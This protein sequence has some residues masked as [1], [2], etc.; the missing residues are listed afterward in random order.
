MS[1]AAVAGA[2]IGL[3]GG[4]L[5]SKASKDNAQTAQNM[6]AEDWARYQQYNQQAL[7]ANRPTQVNA[8]GDKLSW[9]QDDKGNWIQTDKFSPERQAL[10][11]SQ[12]NIAGNRMGAAQGI[13][14]SRYSRGIDYNALGMGNL[15]QA[16][17]GAPSTSKS[18]YPTEG[19]T[20]YNSAPL[21]PG[22]SGGGMGPK[23]PMPPGMMG[24]SG[25]GN[26]MGG[27]PWGA[28][29]AFAQQNPNAG[30]DMFMA[31]QPGI[32]QAMGGQGPDPMMLDQLKAQQ[33]AMGDRMSQA[34]SGTMG[35][36]NM[37]PPAMMDR[38]PQTLNAPMGAR[39]MGGNLIDTSVGRPNMGYQAPSMAGPNNGYQPGMVPTVPNSNRSVLGAGGMTGPG[40]GR[41]NMPVAPA[42]P[43]APA[44]PA[45]EGPWTPAQQEALAKMLRDQQEAQRIA[46]FDSSNRGA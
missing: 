40:I 3:V 29:N 17:G 13:D 20:Y 18:P 41:L 5:Q 7:Q 21:K 16:A 26:M 27:N 24:P 1:W 34:P 31:T 14:L 23:F 10:Y 15:A 12:L 2:G 22:M 8:L 39:S 28:A 19:G 30:R 35:R 32:A 25:G 46:S 33:G 6:S 44:A 11:N 37:G 43:V 38:M 4:M 9:T 36:Q 42:T 45:Q